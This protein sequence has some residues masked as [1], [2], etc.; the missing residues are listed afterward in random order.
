[1]VDKLNMQAESLV[2]VP[3]VQ[4]PRHPTRECAPRA[5]TQAL[6]GPMGRTVLALMCFFMILIGLKIIFNVDFN[7]TTNGRICMTP[8]VRIYMTANVRINIT[9][10]VWPIFRMASFFFR[11]SCFTR[12]SGYPRISQLSCF[13]IFWTSSVPPDV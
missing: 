13:L 9:T 2:D 5:E 6:V 11:I 8:N 12:I 1:M 10:N 4:P 3:R 7:M